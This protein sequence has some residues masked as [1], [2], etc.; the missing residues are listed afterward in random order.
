M[1]EV[2]VFHLQ[3]PA[4][5]MKGCQAYV[6]RGRDALSCFL[7]PLQVFFNQFSAQMLKR[8]LFWFDFFV[9]GTKIKKKAE[10][11]SIRHD[12]VLTEPGNPWKISGKEIC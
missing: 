2:G 1:H 3:I 8:N 5:R 9:F 12:G 6:S 7:K 4:E 10:C 11:V